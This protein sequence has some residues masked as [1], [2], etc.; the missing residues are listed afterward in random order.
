MRTREYAERGLDPR[1]AR[2][3]ARARFGDF[4]DVRRTCRAI[5]EGRERD[6]RRREWL[7]EL[8]QDLAFA[9]R[10]LGRTQASPRLR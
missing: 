10:Q 7:D 3:S 9:W 2:E 4:E 6:M 1:A 5:A 8:K